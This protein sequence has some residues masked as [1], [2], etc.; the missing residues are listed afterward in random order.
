MGKKKLFHQSVK[1]IW[2]L[3]GPQKLKY[4]CQMCSKQCRDEHGFKAH[5]SSASHLQQMIEFASNPEAYISLHSDAFHSEFISLLESKY[6]TKRVEANIV[7]QEII[8]NPEHVHINAT[9]W[10]NLTNYVKYLGKEGFCKV[11]QDGDDWYLTMPDKKLAVEREKSLKK[12]VAERN[13]E[14]REQLMLKEQIAKAGALEEAPKPTE[15]DAAGSGTIKMSLFK[16]SAVKK[17]K[18]VKLSSLAS[19][20]MDNRVS[21]DRVS[22]SNNR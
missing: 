19:K 14:E 2:K 9:R 15:I 18:P 3:T 11:E 7:Y 10:T 5:C 4:F 13:E 17:L 1:K 8:L 21:K 20:S 12:A 16:P 6:T 22:K